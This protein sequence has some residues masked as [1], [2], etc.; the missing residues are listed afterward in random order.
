MT[1][2]KSGPP[3]CNSSIST[4]SIRQGAQIVSLTASVRP[5]VAALTTVL[6]SC[7]H[8]ASEW[9]QLYQQD[10]DF[11]TTYQLLGTGVNVTD[12]HIQDGML[13]HLGHLCVPT[14]ERAKMIWEAHYSRMAGHFGMEKT[15]VI[16]Q[17]HFYW[18]KLRQDVNKYIISCTP[19]PFPSQPSRSKAYT[20]LFLLPRSLG[21]P[22][23]WITCLA[24]HPP[25]KEMI[26]YLWSLIGFRRWPS[27]Q[28]TRRISQ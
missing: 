25:S 14:S 13:C 22:S 26:V 10:P 12:F 15:V 21:N 8:E 1:T 17:K 3:T 9:P 18:P 6:H 2:I 19:V 11:A 7:G 27:S 24:F 16:L 4:S 20:P 5:P 23:Q 28:P